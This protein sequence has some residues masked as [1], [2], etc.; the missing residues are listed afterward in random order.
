MLIID[1][2]MLWSVTL[3]CPFYQILLKI[4]HNNLTFMFKTP[5]M[6]MFGWATPL[7]L[8]I[9]W[10][11]H[12]SFRQTCQSPRLILLPHVVFLWQGVNSMFQVFLTGNNSEYFT[13]SPTAVQGRADIRVRVALPLDYETIQSYSFSVS[14]IVFDVF[15]VG[16]LI[17]M[18]WRL[19][20]E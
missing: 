5:N 12:L 8:F 7:F 16:I 3:Q 14:L 2:Y 11:L 18:K 6:C 15:L 20:L 13:I 17:T 4:R 9:C 1:L 10:S 19:L